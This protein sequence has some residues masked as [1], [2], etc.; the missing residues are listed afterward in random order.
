[1]TAG[2]QASVDDALEAALK[3]RGSAAG[4]EHAAKVA[5]LVFMDA[6]LRAHWGWNT[7]GAKLK[8]TGTGARRYYN[9]NR[10]TMHNPFN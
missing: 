6:A 8:V 4:A 7:I 9:R 5:T 3:L 1:M 10:R 2:E